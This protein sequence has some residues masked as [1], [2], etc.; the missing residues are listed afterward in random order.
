METGKSPGKKYEPKGV[1]IMKKSEKI[2]FFVFKAVYVVTLITAAVV[3]FSE[4]FD[5][6]ATFSQITGSDWFGLTF[7]SVVFGIVLE[8]ERRYKKQLSSKD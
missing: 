3:Y 1:I 8:R 2:A 5:P 7:M 4:F 6:H